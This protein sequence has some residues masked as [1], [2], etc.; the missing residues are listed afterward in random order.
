MV[1][2]DYKT[3]NRKITNNSAH[4]VTAAREKFLELLDKDDRDFFYPED[5]QKIATDDWFVKRFLL[6]RNK[7]VDNAATMMVDALKWRRSEDIRNLKPHYF[8]DD[9]FRVSAMF[10]YA[11]DKEGNLTGT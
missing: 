8:P 9:M 7:S 1:N 3:P 2:I 6:A 5:I 11:P 10:L 4:L